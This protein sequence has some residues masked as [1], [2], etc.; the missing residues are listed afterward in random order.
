MITRDY[1][2]SIT[3]KLVYKSSL[4]LVNYLILDNF[5]QEDCT[6]F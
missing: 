6:I 1:L 2:T 3:V 4:F 5:G